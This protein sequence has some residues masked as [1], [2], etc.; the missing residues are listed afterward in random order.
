MEIHGREVGAVGK[1]YEV[2]TQNRVTRTLV[3][4]VLE[5]DNPSD[6][7]TWLEIEKETETDSHLWDVVGYEE[8]N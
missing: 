4:R 1:R 2:L 8:I 5:G 3:V 7:S 6:P